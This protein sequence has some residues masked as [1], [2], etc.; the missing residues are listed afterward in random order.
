MNRWIAVAT[1]TLILTSPFNHVHATVSEETLFSAPT[2]RGFWVQVT[3][4]QI[5][6]RVVE[7]GGELICTF[8]DSRRQVVVM[9]DEGADGIRQA[10]SDIS[11]DLQTEGDPVPRVVAI[12]P[13]ANKFDCSL[14]TGPDC[15]CAC[16]NEDLADLDYNVAGEYIYVSDKLIVIYALKKTGLVSAY[17]EFA[18]RKGAEEYLGPFRG[19]ELNASME[20]VGILFSIDIDA[21]ELRIS[22]PDSDGQDE[23]SYIPL[24]ELT[25]QEF[26]NPVVLAEFKSD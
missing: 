20:D 3:K 22:K 17:L 1:F 15:G 14:P 9:V 12:G 25:T 7:S 11:V 2:N 23:V 16:L 18:L 10:R 6:S 24:G 13:R 4:Q 19:L 5:D 26:G 8:V 21:R